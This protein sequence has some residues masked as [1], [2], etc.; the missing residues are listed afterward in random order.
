M[1][2]GAF[3]LN[4]V[5]KVLGDTGDVFSGET[6]IANIMEPN[7]ISSF[8]SG[9]QCIEC[10]GFTN[11]T[12]PRPVIAAVVGQ[13]VSNLG[14]INQK[15][16]NNVYLL[17]NVLTCD[18]SGITNIY[19]GGGYIN[20]DNGA[21]STVRP[22]IT[23]KF[24]G[25]ESGN[26]NTSGTS[27]QEFQVAYNKGIND[28]QGNYTYEVRVKNIQFQGTTDDA[29]GTNTSTIGTLDSQTFPT[30]GAILDMALTTNT[31]DKTSLLYRS[32]TSD[33]HRQDIFSG[34]FSTTAAPTETNSLSSS[35]PYSHQGNV[36]IIG[37]PDG[38]CDYRGAMMAAGS[39]PTAHFFSYNGTTRTTS[40]AAT[41]S[42]TFTGDGSTLDGLVNSIP[43]L[44]S[45][46]ANK[47]VYGVYSP[48]DNKIYLRCATHTFG[49][50][51]A[52]GTTT[53]GSEL[54]IDEGY[55]NAA[56]VGGFEDDRFYVVAE[57]NQQGIDDGDFTSTSQGTYISTFITD[58][59]T[60]EQ[61]GGSQK[62]NITGGVIRPHAFCATKFSHQDIGEYIVAGGGDKNTTAVTTETGY[63]RIQYFKKLN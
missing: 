58:G 10:V 49:G 57:K 25:S 19:K 15:G 55:N 31:T 33:N 22:V 43:L 50:S 52:T 34:S 16:A 35:T 44:C 42:K 41:I 51:C 62:K 29:I 40:A 60:I 61:V 3:R 20:I 4:G 8:L 7:G 59:N 54:V 45:V 13:G 27:T 23:G 11:D 63:F 38:G 2:I 6:S 9:P 14:G 5:G 47:I 48:D 36:R 53:S 18:S 28:G 26:T 32:D 17:K 37:L 12:T 30:D 56:I 24:N 39:D 21:V 46:A 1:T